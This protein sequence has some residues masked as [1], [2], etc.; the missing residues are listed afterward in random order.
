MAIERAQFI[1]DERGRKTAVIL[2]LRRYRELIEDLHDIELV[3][4]RRHEPRIPWEEVKKRLRED[5][6]LSD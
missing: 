1:V 6:V 5:G 4:K 2:P 3:E